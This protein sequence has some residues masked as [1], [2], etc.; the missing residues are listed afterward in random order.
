MAQAKMRPLQG[1]A[2]HTIVWGMRILVPLS[3]VLLL[4]SG[5]AVIDRLK[6]K[7]APAPEPVVSA[8]P[9]TA[10]APIG[11]GTAAAAL[12]ATSEAEK[13]AALAAPA[14]TGERELGKV[15]AS[16][17]SPAEQGIWLR[18]TLVKAPGKGRVVIASGKSVAVDLLPGQSGAQLSLAA[19]RALG[20]GLT[21]LPEVTVF[22]N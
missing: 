17:G 12:D 1:D 22:A 8:E 20:L 6:P 16:L 10:I 13:Q 15:A 2:R 5:C 14:A 11:E 9:L 3:L 21:D 18:T 4:G 7:P 19:Y